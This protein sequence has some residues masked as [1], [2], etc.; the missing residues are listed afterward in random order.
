MAITKLRPQHLNALPM[1]KRPSNPLIRRKYKSRK[2]T[3]EQ[4]FPPDVAFNISQVLPLTRLC[5]IF[6]DF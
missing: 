4:L 3:I 5:R 1:V 6:L 2:S